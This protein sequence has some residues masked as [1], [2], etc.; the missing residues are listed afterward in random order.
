MTV[1]DQLYN[2]QGVA[3]ETILLYHKIGFI[4]TPLGVDG[5][6]PTISST[7]ALYNNPWTVETLTVSKHLF[8]NIATLLG[9]THLTGADGR[10]LYL[11]VLDID[12]KNVYDILAAIEVNGKYLLDDL[13][14]STFIVKT[15]KDWGYHIYWLSH[16][17]YTPI[18]TSDCKIGYKFEIK[19]DNSLGHNTLPPSRHRDFEDFH[20]QSIGAEKLEILDK[21]YQV[22]IKALSDCL[23]PKKEKE[24]KESTRTP[25][26]ISLSDNVIEEIVDCIK[27]YHQKESRQRLVL[28]LSGL[29]HKESVGLEDAEKVITTLCNITSDE[30]RGSRIAALK[31]TYKKERKE[32]AGPSILMEVITGLADEETARKVIGTITE[33]IDRQRYQNKNPI[34][35]QLQDHVRQELDPHILEVLC[36]NPLKFII[37]HY[38]KKRILYAYVNSKEEKEGDEKNIQ[39]VRYHEAVIN[40]VPINVIMYSTRSSYCQ[41]LPYPLLKQN[42]HIENAMWN[43]W[44]MWKYF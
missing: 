14:K 44:K 8:K 31:A 30:E 4:N 21:L 13:H 23:K 16:E 41:G 24:K 9:E 11:N 7:N 1:N 10:R 6:T 22:L 34:L 27:D 25:H 35:A 40:A 29:L 5:K 19:T 42:S 33:I 15:K 17:Q 38:D 43:V 12:S 20:Y 39:Q 37:A 28:G 26:T 32:V 18:K 36:F 2:G 3:L